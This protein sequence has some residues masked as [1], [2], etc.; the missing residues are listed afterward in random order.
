MKTILVIDDERDVLEVVRSILKTKGYTVRCAEGGEDG[1]QQA[2]AEQPDLIVCDLMMPRVSGLEVIKRLRA[3]ERFKNI[4]IVVLSAVGEES[5][6][7]SEY[8]ARGLGVDDYIS[9]PFDPL[10]LLGRVEY[11][12]RKRDY[13]SNKRA[14]GQLPPRNGGQGASPVGN[15]PTKAPT[16]KE[17][18]DIT[19]LAP[20]D[21]VKTYVTAWNERDWATEYVCMD[22]KIMAHF[23][24]DDYASRREQAYVE[25]GENVHSQEISQVLEE[26]EVGDVGRVVV[27]RVDTHGERVVRRKVT[28]S[29][30][31]TPEGWRITRYKE[32]PN[33]P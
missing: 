19:G 8:W 5:D 17:P 26:I 11:V 9:K 18:K 10:D 2:E 33:V 12:F 23:P 20:A 6:K 25:E 15:G 16:P 28:F 4:P 27:E 1:L 21:I 7:P 24:L 22:P 14:T 13:V 3:Q 31:Q 32:E 29:L 30:K